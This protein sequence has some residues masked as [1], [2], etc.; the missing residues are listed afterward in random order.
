MKKII[1]LKFKIPVNEIIYLKKYT[2]DIYKD[3]ILRFFM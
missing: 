3:G 1:I 2:H